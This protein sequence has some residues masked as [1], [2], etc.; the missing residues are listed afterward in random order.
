PNHFLDE[1]AHLILELNME[2]RVV[3]KTNLISRKPSFGTWDA[4]QIL[5]LREID[6][7]YTLSAFLE[8]GKEDR[9]LLGSLRLPGRSLYDNP[10]ERVGE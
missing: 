6:K 1:S 3:D 10:G 4:D 5:V 2:D 9:R 8:T 7:N